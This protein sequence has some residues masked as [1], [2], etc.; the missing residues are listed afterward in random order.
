MRLV[1][2]NSTHHL[3][4]RSNMVEQT[5]A[6][7][8]TWLSPITTES[9]VEMGGKLSEVF[10]DSIT[11]VIYHIEGRPLE[12]GRN[13]IV[14]T[15]ED[16]DMFGK[17][18]DARTGVQEYGGAAAIAY[19]GTIY[20]SNYGDN[21]VYKFK[22][23]EDPTPVTPE[24]AAHRF[25][26]LSVH[27]V[28]P[29]IL[30][31]ILEDHTCPAPKDVVTT[32]CTINTETHAVS[33]LVSGADF[34]GYPS[35]SPDGAHLTW[36]QWSHP[37]MPWDGAEI[38]V[39]A[40]SLFSSSELTITN[41]TYVAGRKGAVSACAPAWAS[42]SLLLYT[43]DTSG[44]QNPW[45][46]A[47]PVRTA[48][49]VLPAPINE[50]FSLPAFGVGVRYG[51]PLDADGGQALYAA[52]RNDRSTL[53]VLDLQG[54]EAHEL[55]CPYAVVTDVQRVN[56]GAIAFLGTKV[57]APTRVVLCELV[58]GRPAFT[59]LGEPNTGVRFP[60]EL[61][62]VPRS[63]T[64]DA[65]GD[66]PL[67]VLYLAPKNPEYVAPE[68][69]RPPCVVNVHG[70]PTGR[71]DMSLDWFKQFFTSRGWA[72][73]V[74]DVNYGGSSGYGRKYIN[75]LKGNWGL[76]DVVDCVRAKD[77]LSSPPYSLIDPRRAVIRG[78]SAGG[79]A[80]LATLCAHAHA[81]AA[82]TSLYGI[83][84]LRKLVEDTHKFESRY[85]ETLLGG[86]YEEIPA[87][88][89]ER[90]PLYNAGNIRTP[91]LVLQ[92]ADDPVVPP[93]QADEI[94]NAIE[95]NGGEVKCIVFDGEGHGWRKAETIKAALENELQW[96]EDRVLGI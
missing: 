10:V 90:S 58:D 6:P 70:G 5:V 31:A 94:V 11:S 53:Y 64:L 80:T 4:V 20:F 33:L 92:G 68:G 72:W 66:A 79:Y 96:Y 82:G 87:V 9:I 57:D 85:V 44:Y 95:K 17:E 71:A 48:T 43:S 63:M 75:R 55:D 12:A 1:N 3:P 40:V 29:H 16:R 14:K 27:P 51:V 91:L 7:Y 74:L 32:L 67:H 2:R 50:E 38:Y 60:P 59:E 18:W 69:E 49:P 52:T 93:S 28:N 19:D 73:C 21:R 13:V 83:A 81:F 76:F 78:G 26:N 42:S 56:A 24:N 22:D 23:G 39:A 84:D 25:A 89:E 41:I 62:S 34:Y 61:I 37:D 54:R 47:L 88:Y 45:M 15:D 8:G 77:R 36:Q 65:D 46:Y 86:T 35:F 30:V